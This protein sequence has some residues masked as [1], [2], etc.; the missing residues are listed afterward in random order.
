MVTLYYINNVKKTEVCQIAISDI[1][2]SASPV[3]FV[4][5]RFRDEGF[6]ANDPSRLYVHSAE[7]NGLYFNNNEYSLKSG[8]A[9]YYSAIFAVNNAQE[10]A[11]ENG[12]VYFFHTAEKGHL[13][14]PHIHASYGGETISVYFSDLHIIG[15]MKSPTRR[16]MIVKYV[17]E[18]LEA[19]YAEWNKIT[20]K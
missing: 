16:R 12:I 14:Y 19:L 8:D 2:D 18:N 3:E 6:D 7:K 13:Y 10:Y 20:A 1:S 4:L 15:K 11:R 5:D 9:I 17:K